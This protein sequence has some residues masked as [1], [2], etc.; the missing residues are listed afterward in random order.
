MP[1]S[2]VGSIPDYVK[3][4]ESTIQRQWMHVFNS[5]YKKI[6]TETESTNDAE[7]RAMMAANSQLKKRF[8]GKKSME[9]NSR[10]DYFAHLVDNF[11]SNLNG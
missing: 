7:K 6:M 9:K 11:L 2:S 4:Y 3:K 8:T 10:A 5:V 1:Y